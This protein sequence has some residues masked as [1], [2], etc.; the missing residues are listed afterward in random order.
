M[1]RQE[2]APSSILGPNCAA[3]ANHFFPAQRGCCELADRST[4]LVQVSIRNG[5]GDCLF[6]AAFFHPY[7]ARRTG[8]AVI[9]M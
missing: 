5:L 3:H 9:N 1:C 4:K 7:A 8:K 6:S 2:V